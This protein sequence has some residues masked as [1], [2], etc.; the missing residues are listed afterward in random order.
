MVPNGWKH[1]AFGDVVKLSKNK[2]DPQKSDKCFP[3]VELEHLTQETGQI[4][5]NRSPVPH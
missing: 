2:Y 4:V 5:G 3:C 1:K